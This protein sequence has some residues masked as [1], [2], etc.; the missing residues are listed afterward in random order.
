V[1]TYATFRRKVECLIRTD[2]L[3]HLATGRPN[4][5]IFGED[6]GLLTAAI[7]SRGRA[8]RAIVAD[9]GGVASCRG[10]GFPCRTLELLGTL[11]RAYRRPLVYYCGPCPP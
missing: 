9:P 11:D 6:A 7:G 1:R 10:Q 3:P 8:A 4:V 2:V 5:V